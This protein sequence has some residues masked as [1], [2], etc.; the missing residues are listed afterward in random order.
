MPIDIYS[1]LNNISNAVFGNNMLKAAFQGSIALG[2][3]I[4]LTCILLI[5]VLYPAKS[6]TSIVVVFKL[7]IYIF[8][9]SVSFIFIH[10]SILKKN[11][12]V[13]YGQGESMDFIRGI[14]TG[15]RDPV[16]SHGYI[17]IK[18]STYGGDEE[19]E[20]T[21]SEDAPKEDNISDEIETM[22]CEYPPEKKVNPYAK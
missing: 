14:T 20:K 8:M 12:A 19:E 16:Y 21:M 17:Q 10:D 11:I 3:V 4:A 15:G 22:K 1:S 6:G 5:M 18:P 13:K 2:F 7:F 9:A